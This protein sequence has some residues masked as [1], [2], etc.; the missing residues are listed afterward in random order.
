[1][2]LPPGV[3][4]TQAYLSLVNTEKDREFARGVLIV[5]QLKAARMSA[6]ETNPVPAL[7]LKLIVASKVPA[8]SKAIAITYFIVFMFVYFPCLLGF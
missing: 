4:Q 8:D 5:C 6:S 1:L 7:G 2:K 3:E